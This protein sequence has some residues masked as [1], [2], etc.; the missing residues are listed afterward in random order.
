M[1]GGGG[2]GWL[3]GFFFLVEI[4]LCKQGTLVLRLQRESLA[5]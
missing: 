1:V 3:V 4:N 5:L 2:G